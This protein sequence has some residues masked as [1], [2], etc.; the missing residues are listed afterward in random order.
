[1]P[2]SV[3]LIENVYCGDYR[4][5]GHIPPPL[6]VEADFGGVEAFLK[7]FRDVKEHYREHWVA[8]G[9]HCSLWPE[10]SALNENS[11]HLDDDI[12]RQASESCQI[13][14]KLKYLGVWLQI[15]TN[16]P[17]HVRLL[18]RKRNL[19]LEFSSCS[20]LKVCF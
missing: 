8:N 2:D 1:M 10:L 7:S 9:H 5:Y 16:S 17:E 12:N 18:L 20:K 3:H 15:T 6:V 19:F 4:A 13:R 11:E 14:V